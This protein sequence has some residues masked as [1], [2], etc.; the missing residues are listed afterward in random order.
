VKYGR[1][2]GRGHP[3]SPPNPFIFP[4]QSPSDH[5]PFPFI[6]AP[7]T[8]HLVSLLA[9]QALLSFVTVP[10]TTAGSAIAL[11]FSDVGSSISQRQPQI[12]VYDQYPSPMYDQYPHHRRSRRRRNSFRTPSTVSS[13]IYSQTPSYYHPQSPYSHTSSYYHPPSSYSYVP[14]TTYGA[15]SNNRYTSQSSENMYFRLNNK[16]VRT[17]KVRDFKV[18]LFGLVN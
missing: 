11:S 15:Y 14:P 1:W 12:P 16:L 9:L 6:E 5:F 7:W 10:Y 4:T 2:H 18:S 17:Y 8:P 3:L 13:S